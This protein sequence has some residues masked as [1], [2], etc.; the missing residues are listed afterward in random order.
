MKRFILFFLIIGSLVSCDRT[1]IYESYGEI[2]ANGWSKDS[3]LVFNFDIKDT[4][5][6]HNLYFNLRNK[7]SY[8][9]S[10]V[11]LFL[12]IDSP[13][14]TSVADTVE[15]SLA[16]N[17]GKWL[18]SGLGD[19]FDNQI[20]YRSNVYFPQRGKYQVNIQH[21][22]RDEMLK[23]ICDVGIRVEKRK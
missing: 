12:S 7:G 19:L 17:S 20:I 8:P 3:V 15:I 2:D 10:N 23:G 1:R 21:G 9:Y 14:G 4:V 18:G 5:Q 16:D 13:D 6:A 22:M 11:W